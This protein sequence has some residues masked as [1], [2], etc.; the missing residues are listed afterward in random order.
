MKGQF[1]SVAFPREKK[2]KFD[3]CPARISFYNF[4]LDVCQQSD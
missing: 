4:W 2:N 1:G 3:L